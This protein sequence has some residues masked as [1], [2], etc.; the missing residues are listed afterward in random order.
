MDRRGQRL[1]AIFAFGALT[2]NYPLLTLVSTD[3]TFLGIPV[4]YT[5]LF[6]LWALIIGLMAWVIERRR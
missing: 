5:Y 4:L 1:A 2:L 3:R 6:V